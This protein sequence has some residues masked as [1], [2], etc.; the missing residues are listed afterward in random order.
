MNSSPSG[1]L[2]A[3]EAMGTR[4]ECVL[5]DDG[6]GEGALRAAGEA[7]LAE[8][9]DLDL[10]LSRFRR[11]ALPARLARQPVGAPLAVD[12]ATAALFVEALAIW[13]DSGGLFDITLAEAMDGL[14]H[15]AS[16]ASDRSAG[17][18]HAPPLEID[19]HAGT[20]TALRSVALDLGGIAKGHAIDVARDLLRDAGVTCAF[21]HGGTSAVAALGAPPGRDAWIVEVAIPAEALPSQREALPTGGGRIRLRT[22]EPDGPRRGVIVALRDECLAVSAPHGRCGPLGHHII[23]PR[24]G[25]PASCAALAVVAGTSCRT[26]DAWTKPALIL[27]GPPPGAPSELEFWVGGA[28]TLE[29]PDT[30]STPP[31]TTH[32]PDST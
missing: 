27:G 9:V 24:T 13:R 21:I 31:A 4:F 29:S 25:R 6:R 20:I 16:P 22:A 1:L 3:C 17:P 10:H 23:D 32:R 12:A 5:I 14:L 7:A 8:V 26:C 19:R 2:L 15:G 11:E 28:A 18:A 30:L